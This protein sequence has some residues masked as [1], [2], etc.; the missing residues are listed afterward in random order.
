MPGMNPMLYK[1]LVGAG[2]GAG[3]GMLA[4]GGEHRGRDALMGG[5]AGGL[6]GAALGHMTAPPK[7]PSG[8]NWAGLEDILKSKVDW[9]GISNFNPIHPPPIKPSGPP[10]KS[11]GP[12]IPHTQGSELFGQP[13]HKPPNFAS[14]STGDAT[15]HP[16][17]RDV[18]FGS[19]KVGSVAALRRFKLL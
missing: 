11:S 1:G 15:L 5:L 10:I 17:V 8:I 18:L 12:P 7:P 19:H 4:G 13:M 16:D 14:G 3:A 6:G 9:D 2:L